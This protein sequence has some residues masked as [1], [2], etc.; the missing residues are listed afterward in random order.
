MK[1]N[2]FV[3]GE[4][5]RGFVKF[6]LKSLD[7]D[8]RIQVQILGGGVSRLRTV[9]NQIQRSHDNG[10][11]VA[12]LLDA[13]SDFASRRAEVKKEISRLD[14][15]VLRTFLLPD[16]EQAGNL[17]TLLEQMAS[18]DH[19]AVYGCLDKYEAC[20]NRLDSKY[21]LPNQKARI[22][23]YCEAVGAKTGPNKDYGCSAHWNQ[24][25]APLKQLIRFLR[26]L[27]DSDNRT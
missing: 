22:Y 7:F 20:L 8:D 17:E 14:L 10:R 15:P 12:L 18:V 26:E 19:Q 24:E 3:E 9:S 11:R 23:A 13:D 27:A 1:W 16:N 4:H 21:V 6:L 5:D 25:A 2:L